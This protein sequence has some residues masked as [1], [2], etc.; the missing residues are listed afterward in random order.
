MQHGVVNCFNRRR[1]MFWW[2]VVSCSAVTIAFALWAAASFL[3]VADATMM[4][5]FFACVGLGGLG[6]CI[7]SIGV[8]A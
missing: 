1:R 4:H 5:V 6:S 8:A 2:A 7:G 3:D